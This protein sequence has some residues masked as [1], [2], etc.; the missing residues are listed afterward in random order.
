MAVCLFGTRLRMKY[1]H[2]II[3]LINGPQLMALRMLLSRVLAGENSC[4]DLEKSTV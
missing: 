3:I 1:V 2:V 4:A